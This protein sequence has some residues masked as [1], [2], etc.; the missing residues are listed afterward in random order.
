MA[1]KKAKKV[2]IDKYSKTEPGLNKWSLIGL[3]G[4]FVVLIGLILVLQPSNEQQ[5]FEKYTLYG[6]DLEKDHPFYEVNYENKLFQRGLKSILEKEE[7]VILFIGNQRCTVCVAHIGPIANY[8]YSKGMD[9]FV[10]RIYY[11]DPEVN[12]DVLTKL[13]GDYLGISSNIP[14]L[15]VF[16]NNKVD[17]VFTISSNDNSQ[18]INSSL[19]TFFTQVKEKLND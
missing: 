12:E 17:S 4:F 14:Q 18:L 6:A 16:K 9:E 3:I 7:V 13:S 8:F 2:K 10:D 15:L 1:R 19:N 5:I 11:L